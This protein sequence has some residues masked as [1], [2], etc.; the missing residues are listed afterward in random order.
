M[1]R[2]YAIGDIHGQRDRLIGAH[3]LIAADRARTGDAEAPVVHVG[4]YVDRGPDSR[5]VLDFLMQGLDAGAPWVL[6]KGNHDA[7]MAD[8][9]DPA[10]G[11]AEVA[12]WLSGIFGGR[13]TLASYDVAGN[14]TGALRKSARAAVPD[15]HVALLQGL[16][17]S[18]RHREVFFCHAGIRPGVP[19]DA[20]KEN[21][22]IWIRDD[23]LLDRREHG[24]LIVH[25]HTPVEAVTHYGNHLNLDTG[26]GYG[27]PVSAVAIE[28]RAVWLLTPDGRVPVTPRGVGA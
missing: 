19:L 12:Y 5:G 7:A 13:S 27:G 1:Q 20:Q 6:L 22:L 14:S 15:G 23:F 17:P 21:D 28:G 2:S 9:L 18:F 25:G 26:A 3:E 8:F 4:D 11:T 24:A 10:S 16:L